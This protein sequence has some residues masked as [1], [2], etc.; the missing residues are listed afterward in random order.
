MGSG[1]RCLREGRT[2]I[3]IGTAKGQ[4]RPS[5]MTQDSREDSLG[6]CPGQGDPKLTRDTSHIPL[7][8]EMA[9]S[10]L[11]TRNQGRFPY[12]SRLRAGLAWSGPMPRIARVVAVG[13]PHHVVQ[14][15]NNREP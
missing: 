3:R 9:H 8:P 12:F 15:G 11:V 2:D 5:R 13:L 4:V 7:S 10:P 6:A 1:K 14:R